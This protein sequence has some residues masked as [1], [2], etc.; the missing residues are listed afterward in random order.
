MYK[1]ITIAMLLLS[2]FWGCL[3]A[4]A[5]APQEAPSGKEPIFEI[6]V[7]PPKSEAEREAER[8]TLLMTNETGEYLFEYASIKPVEETGGK[9]AKTERQVLSRTVF[10]DAKVLEQ[11]NKRYAS[12]LKA[13]EK[14]AYCDMLLVFDLR[15]QFYKIVQTQLYTDGQRLL[16]ESKSPDAWSKVPG[17]SFADTL[18]K[19][20]LQYEKY[21]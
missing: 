3:V 8:W 20:L 14:V 11:L 17:Q 6:S 9:P 21:K 7:R 15:K 16:A 19:F 4:I 10:K 5:A 2:C 13:G 12:N 18:L 1:L